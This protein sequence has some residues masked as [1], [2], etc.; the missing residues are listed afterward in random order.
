MKKPVLLTAALLTV[1]AA[2]AQTGEITSNRGENWLSRD[3]DWG[4][5]FNATPLFNYAGNLFNGQV[6]NS[7]GDGFTFLN[8]DL[9]IRGKK[10]I[11]ANTAYRAQVRIGFGSTKTSVEVPDVASSD[12]NAKVEDAVKQSHMNINLGVGLEKRVGSSRLVGVYGAMFNVGIG[13]SK[14]AYE[15]GNNL[16]A[17]NTT[18][19]STFKQPN[20]TTEQKDGSTF[21]IGLTA[22]AGVEWFFAPKIALSGEYSWGLNLTSQGYGS[23]TTE[24]WNG[25][26][27][28]SSTVNTGEKT[29]NFSIDTGVTGAAMLGV[30]FYFQ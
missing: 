19:T 21:G 13:S 12:P 24:S 25:T 27:A 4:L 3:G 8:N 23:T 29:G 20:G 14:N 16:S 5:T 18:H 26:S 1:A 28:T 15:Y 9:V 10:L 7:L 2:S 22:F 11:D 17:T 6:G 30:N